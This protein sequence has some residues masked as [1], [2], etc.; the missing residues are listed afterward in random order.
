VGAKDESSTQLHLIFVE[1]LFAL[2]I[3]QVAIDVGSLVTLQIQGGT[4]IV[5]SLPVYFHLLL[6]TMVIATS[7]VG[8]RNSRFSGS[9]MKNV[10][11]LDFL[12]LLV[13]VLLVIFYF[14]LVRLAE[15]PPDSSGAIV[16]DA[17]PETGMIVVIMVSYVIWDLLS[18]RTDGRK[19]RLRVWAS[20]VCL[21]VSLSAL[22]M[23]P[24]HSHRGTAV[25]LM[26]MALLGLLFL[27]RA[28][29]L[30]DWGQHTAKSKVLIG[31]LVIVYLAF[32]IVS[33]KAA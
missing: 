6:A 15:L 5:T 26:D 9:Q 14:L 19:L 23:L 31:V 28:M 3:G 33:R 11:S 24:L 21:I 1:M 29:K 8:W 22:W 30:H 13:D 10:F 7:W 25:I 17:S 12:E 20:V 18:C 16:P 4:G 32:T 27:F 2:A